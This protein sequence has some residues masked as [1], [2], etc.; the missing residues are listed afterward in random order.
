MFK[1][2][3][4]VHILKNSYFLKNSNSFQILKMPKETEK[5]YKVKTGEEEIENV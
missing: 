3:N 4:N 5:Q 1:F 2:Y